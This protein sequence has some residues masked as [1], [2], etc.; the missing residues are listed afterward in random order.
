MKVPQISLLEWQKRYS[1][2]KACAFML[3][4][5]RWP[6]GFICPKCG[7]DSSYYIASRKVYQCCRCR[8]QVHPTTGCA[9]VSTFFQRFC[10]IAIIR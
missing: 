7:H 2:E 1:T 10:F 4:K 3:A 9:V 5:Y 6:N 8:N